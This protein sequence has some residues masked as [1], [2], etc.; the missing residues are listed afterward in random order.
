MTYAMIPAKDF[1]CAKQRLAPFLEPHE[2]RQLAQAMLTDT[3]AACSQAASLE[4][5]G[6]VTCNQHVADLAA[7]F[8]AD[9][10][11]EPQARG[12]TQAV[13]FAARA[14]LRQGIN[15]MLTLPGDVPLITAADVEAMVTPPQSPV[16]VVLVPNRDDLGTNAIV[17]SPPGCLPFHFG[18]DSFQ[19]HLRLAAARHL[20]VEVRR[21]PRLALD[22]DEPVDLAL[23]V[24][25]HHP[26][27][28][29]G[30]L[31][32]LGVVERLAKL[33]PP[34]THEYTL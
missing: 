15:S 26:G 17:L 23:F 14:C 32:Q 1:H 30:V 13:T 25:Q 8:H 11:W 12:H 16:S 3:L 34:P 9:V 28:S 2:R 22:I 10:L 20:T 5:V 6:V 24:T 29:L 33:A 27:H 19:R 18:Y 4:G 31:T 21:L 7:S